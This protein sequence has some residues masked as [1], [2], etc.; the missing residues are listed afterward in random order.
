M[1]TSGRDYKGWP[2]ESILHYPYN[3]L[4][5]NFMSDAKHNRCFLE[6]GSF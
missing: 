1:M 2:S 3:P 4:H 6:N 5:N